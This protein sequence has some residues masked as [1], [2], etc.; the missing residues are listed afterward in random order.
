[1]DR[2]CGLV[3]AYVVGSIASGDVAGTA[4]DVD[5]LLVTDR[6]LPEVRR[7]EA[8]EL[9]A[10]LADGSPL[11]GLE[12]VL[13]RT[14]VLSSPRHP[15]HYELN[16]NGGRHVERRVTTGGDPAFW[17]L[18]DVDAARQHAIAYLGPP[19]HEVIAPIPDADVKQ[20]LRESLLWHR[21]HAG[22][23]ADAALNACRTLH[24]LRTG[25]WLSKTAAGETY[26]AD[27]EDAAVRTALQ[28]RGSGSDGEVDPQQLQRL[29][30][31]VDTAL[32]G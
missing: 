12:A 9:L 5:L 19:A 22:A 30:D 10:D 21:A 20:A 28:L 32:A 26:L 14:D 16:V 7:L 27:R 6:K 23:S 2:E 8:G 1:M 29:L 24:W 17:F 31:E 4:S 3:A 15:L 13:Y 25:I 11:R 18:L